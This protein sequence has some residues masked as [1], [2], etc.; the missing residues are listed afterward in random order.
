M[1]VISVSPES[2]EPPPPALLVLSAEGERPERADAAA[3]RA[4]ILSVAERLFGEKGPHAVTMADIARAAGVGQGTL[5]RRFPRKPDLCLALMDHQFREFQDATLRELGRMTGART[6]R[7]DQLAWVVE[8]F[9]AFAEGNLDL[10]REAQPAL[11]DSEAGL[12]ESP[13][14]RWQALTVRGLLQ[15]AIEAGEVGAQTDVVVVADL[16]LAPLRAESLCFLRHTR[17]Y[18][19]PRVIAAMTTLIRSLRV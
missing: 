4:R 13:P 19:L 8:R 7:L 18:A 12:P 11:A 1:K 16:L 10:L 2:P 6:P 9:A 14:S 15:A 3:N 5:Y 17:A